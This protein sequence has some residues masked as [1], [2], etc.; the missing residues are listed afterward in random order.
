MK[1]AEALARLSN[2]RWLV[3]IAL[4]LILIVIYA[5]TQKLLG[6]KVAVEVVRT[7]DIVQTIVASGRVETPLRDR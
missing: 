1:F 4:L 6:P 7:E 2:K 5:I 3:G